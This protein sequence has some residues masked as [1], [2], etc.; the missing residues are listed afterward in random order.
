MNMHVT[1]V[2]EEI[3]VSIVEPNQLASVWGQVKYWLE[4][5]EK[6]FR[7]YYKPEHVFNAISTGQMQLWV[8]HTR[9]EVKIIMLTQLDFYPEGIQLRYV[10]IG[11]EV[12]SYRKIEHLFGQS[13]VWGIKHGAVRACVIGREGWIKKL[14][15][16]GY[17]K[18]SVL[19]VK[20]LVN[21]F[22]QVWSH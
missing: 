2:I 15:K 9:G 11:G 5:G 6:I 16:F 21:K 17:H 13:E 7:G 1:D 19:L 4:K 3:K 22:D 10:Y 18:K 8:G 12:G 14:A 20:E